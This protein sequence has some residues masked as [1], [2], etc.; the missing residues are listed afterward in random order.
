MNDKPLFDT[1]IGEF[2]AHEVL[3]NLCDAFTI[4]QTTIVGSLGR[5][6]KAICDIDLLIQPVSV[7]VIPGIIE[8][9]RRYGEIT[10][11]AGGMT[12]GSLARQVKV[13]NVMDSGMNLDLFLCHPPAQWGVLTAVRLNTIPF[14]IWAKKRLDSFG[15]RRQGG[16]IFVKDV[17]R[18]VECTLPRE[19]DWF[20]LLGIPFR[21]PEERWTLT[22][23]LRLI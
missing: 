5:K 3:E 14:V 9:L 10:R 23:E 13:K 18:E 12:K 11:G 1:E 22:R 8:E 20:G 6:E 21:P 7:K 17:D 16:T 19:E 4:A 15:Y 2:I